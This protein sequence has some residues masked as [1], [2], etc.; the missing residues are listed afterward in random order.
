MI[1][2]VSGKIKVHVYLCDSLC[3]PPPVICRIEG[4]EGI[5]VSFL[6]E[7]MTHTSLQCFLMVFLKVL[8]VR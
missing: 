7:K 1:Q 5:S 4:L 3:P 8:R 2:L 6:E